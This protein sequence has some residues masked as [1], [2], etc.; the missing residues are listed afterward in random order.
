MKI[1]FERTIAGAYRFAFTNFF[2]I[3]GIGWFPYLLLTAIV[4]ALVYYL[5]PS[6]MQMIQVLQV[7]KPDPADAMRLGTAIL[8]ADALILPLFVLISS[9]VTVGV[10]RKALGQHP[11]PVFFFFSLGGQVWRLIG[12]Y[13]LILLLAWGG[14]IVAGGLIGLAYYLLSKAAPAAAAPISILLGIAAF[15]YWI[16]AFVRLYFFVPAVVVAENH[17]GIRRSWHLGRGNFWRIV[18]IVL[19]MTIPA[20]IAAQMIEGPILQ[21]G[22]GGAVQAQLG[23]HPSP[24]ELRGF[25]A[26][27]LGAVKKV[28]PFLL[29]V[30]LIHLVL[31]SGLMGGAVANAYNLVTGGPD[32]APAPVK[33]SA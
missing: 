30:Q 26:L 19:I 32:I 23:P 10:M 20:G 4:G 11:G 12:S 27:L 13:L 17:I 22:L 14:A 5:A 31:L 29:L 33:A 24:E 28:G 6:F 8:G 7:P 3:L 16:Y 9:M 15:L 25:F 21:L 2:S 18:G 1:P